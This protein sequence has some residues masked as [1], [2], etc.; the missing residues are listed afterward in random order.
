MNLEEFRT[1]IR[2][3]EQRVQLLEAEITTLKRE[4]VP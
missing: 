4:S 2:S 3:L 1:G